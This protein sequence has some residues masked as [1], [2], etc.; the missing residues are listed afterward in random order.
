MREWPAGLGGARARLSSVCAI[1]TAPATPPS[2]APNPKCPGSF[3]KPL[4]PRSLSW[5]PP[6]FTPYTHKSVGSLPLF[7]PSQ[8]I[9]WTSLSSQALYRA[10]TGCTVID[11][12][13]QFL[14]PWSSQFAAACHPQSESRLSTVSEKTLSVPSDK[15]VLCLPWPLDCQYCPE[16]FHP[17]TAARWVLVDLDWTEEQNK[18][19]KDQ[20]GSTIS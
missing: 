2:F 8:N 18:A 17:V 11:K 13:I 10:L 14:S 15:S 12:E 20:R 19:A 5:S 1:L 6:H 4:F 16:D 3:Q 9:Y 7:T